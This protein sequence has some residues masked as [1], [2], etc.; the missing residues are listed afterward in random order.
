M[1]ELVGTMLDMPCPVPYLHWGDSN[2]QESKKKKNNNVNSTM[3]IW[4]YI[5]SD[6]KSHGV[7]LQHT[8]QVRQLEFRFSTFYL[9]GKRLALQ[10]ITLQDRVC[11]EKQVPCDYGE[12]WFKSWKCP[13]WL[14]MPR[15]IAN[16]EWLCRHFSA[17]FE[18][19][20]LEKFW[21]KKTTKWSKHIVYFGKQVKWWV[22][23][24]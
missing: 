21:I 24:L 7:F 22:C 20:L 8:F 1:Q 13:Q 23:T 12:Y 16:R 5:P 18:A 6:T 14:K 4:L 11:F 2:A 9:R 10:W 19:G 17:L 15:A 3:C